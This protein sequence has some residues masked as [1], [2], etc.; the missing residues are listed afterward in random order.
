L[1]FF[2]A[3]GSGDSALD[4]AELGKKIWGTKM[5]IF[6]PPFSCHPFLRATGVDSFEQA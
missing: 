2:A 1:R 4:A 3:K 6:L 5:K